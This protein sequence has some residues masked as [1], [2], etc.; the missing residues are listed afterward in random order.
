MNYY[1]TAA[2]EQLFDNQYIEQIKKR[3]YD[4]YEIQNKTKQIVKTT[5]YPYIP[6]A[7]RIFYIE[8]NGKIYIGGISPENEC[9]LQLVPGG[10]QYTLDSAFE[11]DIVKFIKKHKKYIIT[12][13]LDNKNIPLY[14]CSSIGTLPAKL[15]ADNGDILIA[16]NE[17]N[18]CLYID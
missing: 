5:S 3:Y 2:Q 18:Y 11:K 15:E 13:A 9:P 14:Y 16:E 8:G 6:K 7:D 1:T 17:S 12:F 10:K 4:I